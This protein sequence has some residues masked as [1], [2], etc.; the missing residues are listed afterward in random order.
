[1]EGGQTDA[2]GLARG[3]KLRLFIWTHDDCSSKADLQLFEL[4]AELAHLLTQAGDFL[5]LETGIEDAKDGLG[6]TVDGLP[7]NAAAGR[8]PGHGPLGS[9][10]GNGGAG[11]TGKRG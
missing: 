1:M 7:G 11:Q 9:V 4:S 10:K 3:C 5:L 6:F 8:M 2:A